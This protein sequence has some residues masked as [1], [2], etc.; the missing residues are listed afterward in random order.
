MFIKTI[1]CT[2][3]RGG[4]QHT[5]SFATQIVDHYIQWLQLGGQAAQW[6]LAMAEVCPARISAPSYRLEGDK[7]IIQNAK[8]A[9]KLTQCGRASCAARALMLCNV[10]ELSEHT[11]N[12][13]LTELQQVNLPETQPLADLLVSHNFKKGQIM[14]I[15]NTIPKGTTPSMDGNHAEFYK[16]CAATPSATTTIN[17]QQVYSRFVNMLA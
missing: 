14:H 3:I 17:F 12:K 5:T 1:L 15:I 8:R 11:L 2:P 7:L 10:A 13:L 9:K 6:V 4:T 16:Y